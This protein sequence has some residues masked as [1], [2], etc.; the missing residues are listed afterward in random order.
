MQMILARE[1][2]PAYRATLLYLIERFAPRY[3]VTP[4]TTCIE[5]KANEVLES[6]TQQE[7]KLT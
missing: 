2:D 7:G 1:Q 5:A 4:A 6:S 3:Q